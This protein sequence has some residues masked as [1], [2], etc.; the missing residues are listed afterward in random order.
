MDKISFGAALRFHAERDPHR[1]CVTDVGS[2]LTRSEFLKLA[3]CHARG[4]R[5]AGVVAGDIVAVALPNDVQFLAISFAAWLLGAAPQPLSPKIRDVELQSIV[6]AG[7]PRVLVRE[8]GVGITGTIQL[9]PVRLRKEGE[10][11]SEPLP[12]VVSPLLRAPVSG[13]STG[14]PKVVL[15]KGAALVDPMRPMWPSWHID[16]T[17]LAPGRLYH[18]AP[19]TYT[20]FGLMAGAHVVLMAR[21]DPEQTLALVERHRA[22]WMLVVPTM[23][24][25]IWRLE[26]EIRDRYDLSSIREIFHTAAPCPAWLK[27]AW[28]G[29][30]GAERILELY[31]ATESRAV[32]VIRGDDWLLR[33]KSVGRPLMGTEMRI[34][35]EDGQVLPTGE[36]GTIYMRDHA[37]IMPRYEYVGAAPQAIGDGWESVG[38]MGWMDEDGYLYIADRRTDMIVSGGIN[39]YPAEIEAAI[40]AYAGVRSSAVIGLPDPEYGAVVHAIVDAPDGIEEDALRT[41]LKEWLTAYKLP[42]SFE[43]VAENLRDDSGKIRRSQLRADRLADAEQAGAV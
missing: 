35:G 36:V 15:I 21:F 32:T 5:K 2:T 27:E 43:F 24:H 31:G 14:R 6:D 11:I 28:I 7:R 22:A 42:R 39:I 40:E 4:L 29:W 3:E 23:M 33:P 19:F 9:D 16:D 18:G 38:D 34:C 12:D 10:G 30:L 26:P 1:P 13:G 20:T 17:H 8:G 37:G 41:H 25:R